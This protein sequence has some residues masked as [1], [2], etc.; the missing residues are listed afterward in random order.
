MADNIFLRCLL[1][2]ET[3]NEIAPPHDVCLALLIAQAMR[4]KAFTGINFLDGPF[5]SWLRFLFDIQLTTPLVGRYQS[6]SHEWKI[7][8]RK[9]VKTSIEEGMSTWLWLDNMLLRNI[10]QFFWLGNMLLM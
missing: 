9:F 3:R 5:Y 7:A 2:Q 8:E 6:L 10:T 1:F 4:G